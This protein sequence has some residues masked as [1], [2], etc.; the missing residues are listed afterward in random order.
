MQHYSLTFDISVHD[1]DRLVMAAIEH[2]AAEG[3]EADRYRD[4]P[5]ACLIM[6]L[7]PGAGGGACV[8]NL[9]DLGIEIAQV[10]KRVAVPIWR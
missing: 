7:D 5:E 1:R 3:E 8:S 9:V 2:A 6:L 4:D 10:C